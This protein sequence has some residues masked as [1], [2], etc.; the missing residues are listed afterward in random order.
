MSDQNT[1]HLVLSTSRRLYYIFGCADGHLHPGTEIAKHG[2][3]T[4]PKCDKPV[5][6]VT[7][8]D[9]GRQYYAFARQDLSVK[10]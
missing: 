7:D 2:S 1:E 8:T 3:L 10:R 9:E 6:D 5:R 4:C